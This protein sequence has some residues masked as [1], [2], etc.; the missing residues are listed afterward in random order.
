MK[1]SHAGAVLR[2]ARRSVRH[3]CQWMR[4]GIVG[5]EHHGFEAFLSVAV[6]WEAKFG[7]DHAG[8]EGCVRA[9]EYGCGEGEHAYNRNRV[10]FHFRHGGHPSRG[11]GGSAAR[12]FGW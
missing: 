4:G 6:G 2:D 3:E 7:D 11:T 10:E 12:A 8:S 5:A 1:R 9:G